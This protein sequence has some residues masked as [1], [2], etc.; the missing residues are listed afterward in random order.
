MA[1]W[2]PWHGCQK[3]SAGCLN[4]YVYRRDACI[5][6]NARLVTK[7]RDFDLPLRRNRQKAYKLQLGAEPVYTC[8]TSDFFLD[9][10]DAWRAELWQMIRQRSDLTFVI[11]TKRIH[12]FYEALPADWGEGYDNVR[13]MVTCE[14]QQT[15]DERLPLL[16]NSPIRHRSVIHEPMLEE[17]HIETYLAS[18]KIESVICGGESGPGARLCDYAWIQ[19][20]RA[21]CMQY[22]VAFHFMQTGALFRKDGRIYHLK[23]SD[24]LTQAER[25]GID[26]TPVPMMSSG[27]LRAAETTATETA[28]AQNAVVKNS[29]VK[30]VHTEDRGGDDAGCTASDAQFEALFSRLSASAFRS[31]FKLGLKERAYVQEKGLGVIRSHA[32]DFVRQRLAPAFPAND[33]KQTP[34]RGHPVF[35]AQHATGTCC[36]GCLAKWHHI[37]P[38][39]PLSEA[40]QR[41]VVS[42][43]MEWIQ[44]QLKTLP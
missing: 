19:A 31:R 2:N 1:I 37:P 39:A 26:W 24:Q 15:A 42:V 29:S 38:A 22:Q 43:I 18:G 23:R 33:G 36:R 20:S 27:P 28:A 25:A 11:I 5:G 30:N 13:I 7:T 10:A 9:E 14:N 44:R 21:Q 41:Y 34:M 3:Y 32:E 6:K 8:M 4:C 12:R 17:I 40:Q 35:L 16:L